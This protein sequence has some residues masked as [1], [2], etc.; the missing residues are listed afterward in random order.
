M[1]V[2]EREKRDQNYEAVA[3]V[4]FELS[5]FFCESAAFFL[6]FLSLFLRE[7]MWA[8]RIVAYEA[9]KRWCSL[10]PTVV[11]IV[12]LPS[13]A[14]IKHRYSIASP[15]DF[16]LFLCA[17]DFIDDLFRVTQTEPFSVLRS[18]IA[19]SSFRNESVFKGA[20][21]D[22]ADAG[23]LDWW[24]RDFPARWG[25]R[26]FRFWTLQREGRSVGE[27]LACE[28]KTV[29]FYGAISHPHPLHVITPLF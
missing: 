7:V 2:M 22:N 6:S 5:A 3:D 12:F 21:T 28:L 18:N 10:G 14:R 8:F 15:A 13:V 9:W 17:F 26:E 23:T 20:M 29:L 25:F 1:R 4:F 19:F 16:I 11:E 24:R 27:D